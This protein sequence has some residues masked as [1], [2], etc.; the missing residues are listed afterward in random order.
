MLAAAPRQSNDRRR[1]IRRHLAVQLQGRSWRRARGW[2]SFGSDRWRRGASKGAG[3][4]SVLTP[5]RGD[6]DSV[7]VAQGQVRVLFDD[8][9]RLVTDDGQDDDVAGKLAEGS[10]GRLADRG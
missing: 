3:D 2:C 7:A 6:G 10:D 5:A 8:F 4:R 9:S 1:P